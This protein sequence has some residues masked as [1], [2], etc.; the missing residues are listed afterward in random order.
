M[1]PRYGPTLATISVAVLLFGAHTALAAAP[2]LSGTE[3]ILGAPTDTSVTVNAWFPDDDLVAYFEW[4]TEPGGDKPDSSPVHEFARGVPQ[5]ILIDGLL[6]A[7]EYRYALRYKAAADA[8]DGGV[9]WET[10]EEYRFVTARLPT[11]E[12]T[13]TIQ[14]DSHMDENTDLAVY[15]RMLDNAVAD[16]PDFH[17]DIGDTPMTDKCRDFFYGESDTCT[18]PVPARSYEE[19]QAL[20]ARQ[21]PFLG[22]LCHSAPLFFCQGNHDGEAGKLKEGEDPSDT[23][24]AWSTR[25]R[26]DHIPNPAPGGGTTDAFFSGDTA[27]DPVVGAVRNSYFSWDWGA[28][29]I[30]V[31]DG[32]WYS[33]KGGKD[34]L[35]EDGPWGQTLGKAQY[36]WLVDDLRGSD[37]AYKL[38]VMHN[39]VGGRCEACG[40]GCGDSRG[41]THVTHLYE[42]GGLGPDCADAWAEQRS[43]WEKP[44]H[45]L[46][47]ETGVTAV[48]HG[49]DHLY[50][51][52][53]L[54]GIVYQLCAQPG[55][56]HGG[57]TVGSEEYGYDGVLRASSGHLRLNVSPERI[58][59]EYVRAVVPDDSDAGGKNKEPAVENGFVDDSYELLPMDAREL[60]PEPDADTVAQRCA[61]RQE[62]GRARSCAVGSLDTVEAALVFG[63]A[64][65]VVL[66][67]AG[68]VWWRVARSKSGEKSGVGRSKKSDGTELPPV[69]KPANDV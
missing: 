68:A 55:A 67:V 66:V 41:G 25:I 37:A 21:R 39:M 33:T 58:L 10:S 4:G 54:D 63:G 27:E 31:L 60:Q 62:E 64:A 19:A 20:W 44:L 24:G 11:D 22:S 56:G 16:A 69:G 1:A 17:I 53:E 15:Q 42:M 52:Q 35:R 32:W 59:V 30:V 9:A 43:G 50:S 13:F 45:P 38:V 28:V 49:H 7:T 40:D 46:F 12:W 2:Q 51:R 18:P 36:D 57:T 14:A 48:F 8:G 65:L 3:I 6:P 61:A 34:V 26:L 29:H 23:L 5:Q 47:V